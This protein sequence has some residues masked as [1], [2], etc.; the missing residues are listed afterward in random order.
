MPRHTDLFSPFLTEVKRGMGK[1]AGNTGELLSE[2]YR[3]V[4]MGSDNLNTVVP[5][6]KDKFLLT[7]VTEQIDKYSG[8]AERTAKELKKR[9][10]KPMETSLMKKVMSRGGIMLNTLFDSTDR[11]IAEMIERG[12]RTGVEEL[13]GRLETLK[14]EGCDVSAVRL[15][16]KIVSFKRKEADRIKNYM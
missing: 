8:F 9:S 4:T 14:K 3:N 10:I 11:H 5:M 6:I 1:N 2:M 16:H 13:E 12:T 15:C 7:N